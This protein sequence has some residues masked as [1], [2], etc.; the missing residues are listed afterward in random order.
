VHRSS[1]V[2][3][4]TSIEGRRRSCDDRVKLQ[5]GELIRYFYYSF[6]DGISRYIIDG[7]AMFELQ[8]YV[9]SVLVYIYIYIYEMCR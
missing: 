1:S 9:K 2:R 3:S 8:I 6:D 4:K 5:Y 7:K